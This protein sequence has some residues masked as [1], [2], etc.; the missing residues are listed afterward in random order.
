M[1]ISFGLAK[2]TVYI[3]SSWK[4]LL[5]ISSTIKDVACDVLSINDGICHG[6]IITIKNKSLDYNY[7][8]FFIS[9][10]SNSIVDC[11]YLVYTTEQALDTLKAFGFNV[12]FASFDVPR[13][14]KD[15]LFNYYNLGYRYV[16]KSTDDGNIYVSVNNSQKISG[17]VCC[18]TSPS[19][20]DCD[21]TFLSTGVCLSISN[22]LG[23]NECSCDCNCC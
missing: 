9:G 18:N 12:Q 1:D 16:Y 13:G 15:L 14:T 6:S 5:S 17:D 23:I 3:I 10:D 21:F 19:F 7:V 8:S 11:S 22:I 4:Q 20:R 2:N